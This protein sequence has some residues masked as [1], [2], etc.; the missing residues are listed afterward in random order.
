[1]IKPQGLNNPGLE[2]AFGV[3][4]WECPES[5]LAPRG[6]KT[7][8]GHDGSGKGVSNPANAR[9]RNNNKSRDNNKS[10][11]YNRNNTTEIRIS[12]HCCATM[13]PVM[14]VAY[15][16]GQMRQTDMDGHINHSPLTLQREEHLKM[17]RRE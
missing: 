17:Y 2:Y 8:R 9:P 6:G 1:V 13:T 5:G 16:P 15:L 12:S 10:N 7:H 14:Q 3:I 4:T 11:N